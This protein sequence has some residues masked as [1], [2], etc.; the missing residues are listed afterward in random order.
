MKRWQKVFISFI[1][2]LALAA[3]ISV[4]QAD[5]AGKMKLSS[6]K[7]TVK[8]GKKKTIKVKNTKKKVKWK[9]KKGKK[10]ISL[11]KKKKKSVTIKGRKPGKAVVT[12]KVGKKK[13]TCKVTVKKKDKK[14]N[15][16]VSDD[17]GLKQTPTPS[18]KPQ[19]G[20]KISIV[21]DPG[22][23][24][25]AAGTT[26]DNG[27]ATAKE[28][29]YALEVAQYTKAA[30]EADG[31]FEV[32]MTRENDTNPS[33]MDR[34]KYAE[35]KDADVMVSIHF[36]S[37]ADASVAQMAT[38][39][40]VW[41]SVLPKYQVT[42][43][44]E[45]ILKTIGEKTGLSITRG[46][47]KQ[48]SSDGTNWDEGKNWDTSENTGVPADYY[49][50]IKGG[51]KWGVPTMI[52]EHAFFTNDKDFAYISTKEGR[53]A[54]GEADAQALISYYTGHTHNWSKVETDYPASCITQGK[55]AKH[56]SI[57]RA[58]TEVG[59]IASVPLPDAH[60]M[61][62]YTMAEATFKE[63]EREV[64]SCR[65]G[66]GKE[67]SRGVEGS[68]G[69]QDITIYHTNDMH[70][71]LDEA[72]GIGRVAALK[73]STEASLLLDAG[74]ATQGG[75]LATL[76]NG[77]YVVELM[78]LAGYDAMATGNHEFDYGQDRLKK[79]ASLA[80]FPIL[81]A[82]VFK[83]G[84]PLLKGEYGENKENNGQYVI[85]EEAGAKIGIFGLTTQK[86]KTSSNPAGTVG[87]SFKDEIETAKEM[88][89][90][91]ENKEVD[92]ILCLAHLGETRD[93]VYTSEDVAEAMTGKYK[94]K[95][96]AIIDGHSHTIENKVVN[97]IQISQTGTGLT[98]VGKMQLHYNADTEDVEITETLLSEADCQALEPE[99]AVNRRLEEME[100]SIQELMQVRVADTAST[101]WGGTIQNVSEGRVHETNL[102][103]LIADSMLDAGEEIIRNGNVEER[104]RDLPIVALENGGGIRTTIQKGTITKGDIINVLPFAN[105]V[106]FKAIT[107]KLLYKVLEQGVSGNAG[108]TAEGLMAGTTADG[109]FAQ[110]G[111]MKFVYDPNQPKGQKVKRVYLDGETEPLEREDE[112]REIILAS[113]DFL[114]AGGNGYDML[115]DLKTVAE[116]GA[117]DVMLENTILKRTKQ[118]TVD[119]KVPVTENRIVIESDIYTPSDYTAHVEIRDANGELMANQQVSYYVDD[120]ESQTGTTDKDGLL[121]LTVSDGPHIVGAENGKN[122]AY[123]CNY[124][125]TG[126]I[127]N[128]TKTYPVVTV[129][130]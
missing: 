118:G 89:D 55:K 23:G 57:C 96:D 66:C 94:G 77:E 70:G 50:L 48:A 91:L 117:L 54:L 3:G 112:S 125:G 53:K 67:E 127:L 103:N 100:E 58:D 74:D 18:S 102:G 1:L 12:A 15:N 121:T 2:A 45:M 21:L 110:I 13:L 69:T 28:K 73:K 123:I 33:L 78:N 7:V 65:Y 10:Y 38:G 111:G 128:Y 83:E 35:S 81:G 88:I 30:L 107:P 79:I 49:G 99:K 61:G 105:V 22:H 90:V 44:P 9:I 101:L 19:T 14:K 24:G 29:D 31:R 95:L 56:C 26:R 36:N 71:H 104:Y 124:T 114:I 5:A 62:E 106:S 41:Q 6:K 17:S 93:V 59:K 72:I 92:V 85:L 16:K 32:Y 46:V 119:L 122:E 47:K 39:A 20:E 76:S 60:F 63:P 97:G 108:L 42:G 130:S 80:E 52:V 64:R 115:T 84:S 129:L 113:N 27:N 43:L 109:G 25:S 11:Q 34:A 120:G 98:N 51:A 4:P 8:V 40:E 37:V 87:I 86:T 75:A 68:S 126:I 116:G 82:N